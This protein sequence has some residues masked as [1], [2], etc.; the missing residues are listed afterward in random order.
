MSGNPDGERPSRHPVAR[1]ANYAVLLANRDFLRL[2]LAQT[3]SQTAQQTVNFALLVQVRGLVAERHISGA[4]TALGLLVFSFATPPILF[5]A[6]AGVVVDR[7][8]KRKVM[9]LV[10]ALRAAAISGYLLVSPSWST[11]TTLG[12]IYL[13]AFTFSTVGQLFGP[14]EGAAIPVLVQRERI[15]SANALF[16]L[17]YTSSQLA[18]FV[19]FG[20]LLTGA[21]GL[22]MTYVLAVSAY[23]ACTALI[24]SLPAVPSQPREALAGPTR[25]VIQDLRE[26]WQYLRNDR[27]L[28]KAI[29]YLTLA[30]SAFLTLVTLAPDF[31]LRTLGLSTGR[32]AFVITPAGLGMLAGALRVGRLRRSM[33]Q[34]ERIIDSALPAAGMALASF[35]LIPS[36]IMLAA[37]SEQA[38]GAAVMATMVLAGILGFANAFVIVPSQALLQER[39]T[40]Y[41]RARVISSFFSLSS[42]TA[43]LPI[44]FAGLLGDLLGAG[45]V[46]AGIGIAITVVGLAARGRRGR[47]AARRTH[48]SAE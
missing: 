15:L 20:P 42:A 1:A 38:N 44:L 8:D 13:L 22:D 4:N 39:S 28:R 32:L 30:N 17:T 16:G 18:G 11:V 19:F 33:G 9:A 3:L 37:H 2:W 23:A 24:L 40:P 7:V 12:Y 43:L 29:A 21:L 25:T 27:L 47:F 31:V 48:A 34:R 5:S 45:H 35:V 26:V 10:N 46:L 14:A 6:V 41:N 36:L